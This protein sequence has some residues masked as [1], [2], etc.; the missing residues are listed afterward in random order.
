MLLEEVILIA[1]IL[2]WIAIILYSSIQIRIKPGS[3]VPHRCE[4]G[5][6]ASNES[7]RPG[8]HRCEYDHPQFERTH[9]CNRHSCIPC[10]SPHQACLRFQSYHRV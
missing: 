1:L 9:F 7:P 10:C 6:K 3:S 2:I 5:H 8:F 4:C